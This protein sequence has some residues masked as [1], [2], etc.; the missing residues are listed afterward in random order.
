MK[1]YRVSVIQKGDLYPAYKI[2]VDAD[3]PEDAGNK[4]IDFLVNAA[5]W[6]AGML[7]EDKRKHLSVFTI[8]KIS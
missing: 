1:K 2:T 6:P 5:W 7:D 3:D 8:E 4:A